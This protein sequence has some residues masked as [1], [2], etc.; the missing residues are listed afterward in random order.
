MGRARRASKKKTPSAKSATALFNKIY[1]DVKSPGSYGGI[2]RFKRLVPPLLRQ[3]AE[4]WLKKQDTYNLHHH[5][6]RK[7]PRLKTVTAGLDQQ[8]QADLIDVGQY[9]DT[10]DGVK[11]LLTVIDTFSRYSWCV[12]IVNKTGRAVSD[13]FESVLSQGR[14]PSYLQTDQGR[15]FTNNTFQTLLKKYNIKFFTSH[16]DDIKCGIVERFNRTLQERIHRY[17]TK[18]NTYFTKNNT[19]RFVDQLA[20]IIQSYNNSH[21]STVGTQPANIT[22]H[23][24]EK[25]W[26][27]IHHKPRVVK[28]KQEFRLG[29]TVRISKSR[30]IFE[31]GYLGRWTTELFKIKKIHQTRPPTY[32]LVDLQDEPVVGIF[33]SQEMIKAERQKYYDIDEILDRR[34]RRGRKEYF[35]SWKGYPK[36]FNKWV[37]DVELKGEK[38]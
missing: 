22:P 27:K 6:Q 31:K 23:N 37:S 5:V 36:K 4:E 21:H 1:Y 32:Q 19:R 13:A 30:K 9:A 2:T 18:N 26:L 16:N 3:K 10:N 7:F 8:W 33:Y 28:R 34:T 24:Q 38:Q 14:V 17:F 20:N 11:F 25:I 29:D 15:E 12:P 35:V